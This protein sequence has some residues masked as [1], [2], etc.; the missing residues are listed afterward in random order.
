MFSRNVVNMII[1]AKD[2]VVNG[3]YD[4]DHGYDLWHIRQG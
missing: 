2:V 1:V 3:N 4:Y